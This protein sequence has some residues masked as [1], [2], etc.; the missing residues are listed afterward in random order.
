MPRV[1]KSSSVPNPLNIQSVAAMKGS[2]KITLFDVIQWVSESA[3]CS[4]A[5]L[6]Y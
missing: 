5:K 1:A 3:I 6:D 4:N 2:H